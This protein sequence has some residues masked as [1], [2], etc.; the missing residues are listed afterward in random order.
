MTAKGVFVDRQTETTILA[1]D[2]FFYESQ[3]RYCRPADDDSDV[4]WSR[5]L[6]TLDFLPDAHE[7][8]AE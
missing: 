7:A 1:P 4:A 8:K 3:T 2:S 5:F 6:V